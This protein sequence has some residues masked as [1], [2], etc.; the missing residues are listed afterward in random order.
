M[1]WSVG[2]EG[3][4]PGVFFKAGQRVLTGRTTF[5]SN[6][7]S[8][9]WQLL[10][11]KTWSPGR[12]QKLKLEMKVLFFFFLEDKWMKHSRLGDSY[13]L[14]GIPFLPRGKSLWETKLKTDSLVS[15]VRTTVGAKKCCL[16]PLVGGTCCCCC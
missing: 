5:C 12:S 10:F 3:V 2:K 15:E 14:L 7:I 9:L 4:K 13:W 1:F 8:C 16:I 11:L 6:S